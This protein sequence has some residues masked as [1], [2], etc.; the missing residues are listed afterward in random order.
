MPVAEATGTDDDTDPFGL[1]L[2]VT[3]AR[4]GARLPLGDQDI[5]SRHSDYECPKLQQLALAALSPPTATAG[6]VLARASPTGDDAA[7]K[8]EA[9]VAA[10]GGATKK[11]EP[12][13]PLC[14]CFCGE[15]VAVSTMWPRSIMG[16][17]P[18]AFIGRPQDA[19][20]CAVCAVPMCS[21]HDNKLFWMLNASAPVPGANKGAEEDAGDE[22][23]SVKGCG[24]GGATAT[25]AVAVLSK[26]NRAVCPDCF[27][28]LEENAQRE[29]Q[30]KWLARAHAMLAPEASTGQRVLPQLHERVVVEDTALAKTGR[31]FGGAYRVTQVG[32]QASVSVGL[33]F[34]SF[35]ISKH[36]CFR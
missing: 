12:A 25:S 36:A 4:C 26:L 13:K 23:T 15:D 21:K 8:K 2:M 20:R 32:Q 14:K 9:M 33:I 34:G 31:I 22:E 5:I 29:R 16:A 27:G 6:M 35:F 30:V 3:C 11:S 18:F 28:K 10:G 17:K 1:T 7:S 19:P 24:E